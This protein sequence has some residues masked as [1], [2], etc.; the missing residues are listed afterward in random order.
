IRAGTDPDRQRLPVC[1]LGGVPLHLVPHLIDAL[2]AAPRPPLPLF[3]RG[4]TSGG[5]LCCPRTSGLGGPT[6][7]SVPCVSASSSS[8]RAGPSAPPTTRRGS[9]TSCSSPWT[10]STLTSA[11]TG[12][13]S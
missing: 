7:R 12:T 4:G 10:T 11:A 1:R 2:H 9:S 5:T 13:R 8:S 3:Y 6:E